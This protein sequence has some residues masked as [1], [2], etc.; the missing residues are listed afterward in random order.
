MTAHEYDPAAD[1]MGNYLDAIAQ[2]RRVRI[3]SGE[4]E[5]GSAEEAG[6]AWAGFQMA[7]MSGRTKILAGLVEPETDEERLWLA[8]YRTAKSNDK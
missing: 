3:M 4:I 5:V 6:W 1:A 2:Q 8:A 7:V